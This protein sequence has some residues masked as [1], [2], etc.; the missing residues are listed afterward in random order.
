MGLPL[1]RVPG[2]LTAA[3]IALAAAFF[4]KA[5]E[6]ERLVVYCSHDAV[7]AESILADFER[8]TGIAVAPRFDTEAT[9]S[10]GLMEL[11]LRE[12]AAPRCDVFWNNELFGTMELAAQGMLDPYRGPGWERIPAAFK[13]EQGRWT[14]FAARLRVHIVNTRLI[15]ADAPEVARLNAREPGADLSRAAIAKPI[16][17]TTLTHYAVLWKTWGPEALKAW[18]RETRRRGLRE[19]PGNGP[20]KQIV[21]QGTC[22]HGLTDT[23]DF[24]DAKD[25]GAPVEMRP[26]RIEGGGTVCIPNT[27]AIIK[28]TRRVDAARRLVDYLLS[29]KVELALARSKA[30]QIP[31][32]PVDEAALP[33]EV[34]ELARWGAEGVALEGFLAARN[35]C[36]AWLKAEGGL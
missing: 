12:K 5:R 14:G 7:F 2:I 26:V 30:R 32:G 24:F 34:R 13:D 29:E 8:E 15:A 31:L 21:A 19:V 16:Y 22:A 23:D 20:V 4:W 6:G 33:E 25:A 3:A 11:L 28:G 9:K 27:V 35:E 1:G 36:L 10:L 17:G 18:H